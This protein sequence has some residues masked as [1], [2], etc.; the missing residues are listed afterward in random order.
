[1]QQTL[2]EMKTSKTNG[3]YSI[4]QQILQRTMQ[5]VKLS[6]TYG[7]HNKKQQISQRTMQNLLEEMWIM[8][9]GVT[10]YIYI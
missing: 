4:K 3:K 8:G 7:K 6:K 2:E 9:G 10:I 1:M 5:E